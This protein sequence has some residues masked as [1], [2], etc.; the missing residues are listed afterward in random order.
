MKTNRLV[1]YKVKITGT[2]ERHITAETHR[3]VAEVAH[4]EHGNRTAAGARTYRAE[5]GFRAD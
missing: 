1:A 2:A 3:I 5:N 4:T